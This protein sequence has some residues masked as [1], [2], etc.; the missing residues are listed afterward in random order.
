M[1]ILAGLL[2]NIKVLKD[3][4]SLL[5]K[6]ALTFSGN[7]LTV[8]LQVFITPLITRLYTPQAYGVFSVF[9]SI[10]VLVTLVSTFGYVNALPLPKTKR[11]LFQLINLCIILS[12][13]TFI[14]GMSVV[15]LIEELSSIWN[16][17][18]HSYLYFVPPTVLLIT[19]TAICTNYNI[20]LGR[21]KQ[22]VQ[23]G[24]LL[25]SSSR[26]INVVYGFFVKG[27]LFGLMIGEVISKILALLFL[28]I[29]DLKV[30]IKYLF[31]VFKHMHL[32][33]LKDT[34]VEYQ[35]YPKYVLTTS[36]LINLS[37]QVPIY[38]FTYHLNSSFVGAFALANSLMNM[39]VRLIGYSISPLFLQRGVESFNRNDQAD[40]ERIVTQL[41]YKMCLIGFIPFLLLT[42]FGDYLFNIFFGSDWAL[43]GIIA[44]S[45]SLSTFFYFIYTPLSNVYNIVRKEK[46]LLYINVFFSIVNI[47]ALYASFYFTNNI[48]EMLLFY[49]IANFIN[50]FILCLL[51]LRAAG[52]NMAKPIIISI[53]GGMFLLIVMIGKFY[54]FIN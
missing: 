40:L 28:I 33:N 8:L 51:A 26:V 49:G 19:L 23:A 18:F 21:I 46:W 20:K 5:S 36:F 29:N 44:C 14:L 32:Y 50:Y 27:S 54:Y 31:H 48:S 45:L 43:A 52:I 6:F 16:Y 22:N 11:R 17:R 42:V 7:F 2:K 24:L 1:S 39:P 10:V 34:L 12:L 38:F 15:F 30:S 4:S 41:Y 37:N 9:N 25:Q 47:G 3:P 13:A 35:S 53:V